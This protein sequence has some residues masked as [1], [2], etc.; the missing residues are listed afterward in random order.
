MFNPFDA[1]NTA[2][3]SA[4]VLGDAY[5]KVR[6]VYENLPTVEEFNTSNKNAIDI[7][8]AANTVSANALA[9][10]DAAA[11]VAATADGKADSAQATADAA[12]VDAGAAQTDATQALTNAAT[13]DDKA[14][15]A[16]GVADT[17][18]SNAAIADDKAVAA[19]AAADAAQS[20][21]TQALSD[22]A[23]ADG[24]AVAA[25]AAADQFSASDGADKVP[26]QSDRTYAA[27]TVGN[28]LIPRVS[29][30]T[31][32]AAIAPVAGKRAHLTEADREGSFIC[33]EGSAPTDPEQGLYVASG[34]A[35]FYWEREWD[36]TNG[37]PEWF[38]SGIW[39]TALEACH[40]L[41]PV[42]NLGARDY[43][44]TDTLI[45]DQS[46]RTVEGARGSAE[47][48]GGTRIILTGTAAANKPVIQVGTLNTTTVSST[49]RRLDVRRINTVRDGTYEPVASNRREDAIPGWLIAGWY[50]S[51]AEDLFDYGSAIH[52]RVYGTVACKMNRCGGVR[53]AGSLG[54]ANGN[55][56]HYTG[57]AI[58]GYSTSFGF[59]GANAS[60]KITDCS[61]AGGS[62]D[63]TMGMY[64]F[65]YIGDTWVDHFEMSQL[66][67]G[68]YVD[69][70]DAAGT[71][72]TASNAHQD[73][74]I[75]N[76]VLDAVQTTAFTI[77]NINAG[78]GIQV[79][80]NYLA[81]PTANKGFHIENSYGNVLLEGNEFIGKIGIAGFGLWVNNSEGV[82]VKGT[83]IKDFY[84]GLHLESVS[85]SRFDMKLNRTS[86]GS[87]E[88]VYLSNVSRSIIA[89]IVT[90]Q[91][92]AWTRA[93]T[94][95]ISVEYCS[96]DLTGIN[97]NSLQTINATHK[98]FYDGATWGGTASFGTENVAS[99]VLT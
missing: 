15:T 16:Q 11:A 48:A 44:I 38:Y 86:S 23:T 84:R 12:V 88:A 99:G 36:G 68:I 59:I 43:V 97:L 89:P 70:S 13:A 14:V 26:Y 62:G 40:L 53:P 32:L 79:I 45:L 65:G 5:E 31:L 18:L 78:G 98:L 34:T 87:A 82:V 80:G 2:G 30:R 17:A 74:S 3:I 63:S 46:Y 50:E 51:R 54:A 33:R 95:L 56:D 35:G 83:I 7:A 49:A 64:L 29:T 93:I 4:E 25:Q 8:T 27:G 75:R 37:R 10:S 28:E 60:L 41:C 92:N 47:G 85:Y 24:K 21:A 94:A 42:M 9:T 6:V 76:S 57:F 81:Q 20:D 96:I 22:A 71:T 61:T 73:V 58:G 91:A 90:G 66:E 77:R 19:Q 1:M 69:G 55:T 39:K 67:H 72:L 52:Y